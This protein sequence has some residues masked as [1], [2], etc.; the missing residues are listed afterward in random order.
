VLVAAAVAA[1]VVAQA[2]PAGPARAAGRSSCLSLSLISLY[3]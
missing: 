1:E 2:G 3:F